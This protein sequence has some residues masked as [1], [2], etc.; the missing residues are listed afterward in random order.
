MTIENL[1]SA[2]AFY[3]AVPAEQR[4]ARLAS[5]LQT[6]ALQLSDVE[7]QKLCAQVEVSLPPRSDPGRVGADI[8]ASGRSRATPAG[9]VSGPVQIQIAAPRLNA[10]AP[11]AVSGID[12]SMM[13]SSVRPQD[14]F[15]RYMNGTW[16]KQTEIPADKTRY[17]S[18]DK[19]ADVAEKT[20]RTIIEA[21]GAAKDRPLGSDAQK[22]GDMYASFMN[23]A[24]IERLSIAPIQADLDAIAQAKTSTDLAQWA[25]TSEQK[26]LSTPFSFSV[27]QDA[28][29]S[30]Q[31]IVQLGQSG[32][33]LPDR[34]YYLRDDENFPEIRQKYRTHIENMLTAAGQSFA[35]AKADKIM[36]LETALAKAQ[37]SIE[38]NRDPAKTYNKKSF[39]EL[40][41]LCPN[42]DWQKYAG[43]LGWK[44]PGDVIVAQPSY[45]TA[46]NDCLQSFS[47]DD[48]KSYY[49]WQV[50][51]DRASLLPK[52]FVDEHFDFYGKTLSGAKEIRPRWKRAISAVDGAE[53]ELVGQLYVEKYFKP[54]AKARMQQL[55]GNLKDALHDKIAALPWMSDETKQKAQAKLEKFTTSKIGYPDKW[56]NYSAL[57]IRPDDLVGNIERANKV[58]FDRMLAKLGQPI[59]R[60]EW[61]MTPQT[62]NAYYDPSMNEIVFPAA[63]L[64]PPFFNMAADDAANYGA[65]GAV[66]GH[67]MTHGFDDEGRQFDGDGNMKDW[68]TKADADEFTRRAQMLVDQYSAYNPVGN[69]HVNGKVTL[70]ENIADFGGLTIAY[71]AYQKSLGGKP[72]PVIDGLTG[73]QRFFLAFAQVWASKSRDAALQEQV[74]T[75][76]HSPTE[77][78]TNGVVTNM[79]EFYNAFGVTPGDPLYKPADKRVQIW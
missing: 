50:L 4:T 17:G 46:L 30:S 35:T 41:S 40:Q 21:A 20:L 27:S 75:D 33:G 39:A 69:L 78:R 60:G 71:A 38:E 24:S 65:I 68:W 37:W 28:K 44:Q 45:F 16:L 57:T 72:A 64:Q 22:V 2:I 32:L 14:D 11:K 76:P 18:F 34:D 73:D 52:K 10:P 79:P 54:E 63:I 49:T 74:L 5:D 62:V 58:E 23:E 53:G 43:G 9:N 61:G 48:W 13:D 1:Q 31:Y 12:Q 51:S 70:G 15:Y 7:Q 8:Y 55:V 6:G 19:V 36:Q 77:Y 67:E 59:D 56:K 47:L 3:C 42:F 25:A 29:N 26:G 66:I